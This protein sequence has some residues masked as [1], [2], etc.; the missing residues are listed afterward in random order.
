MMNQANPLDQLRPNHL[1]DPVSWFPPASGWWLGSL[2][3]VF[4][5][6]LAAWLVVRAIRRTRYR[7]Q[8]RKA[9]SQLWLEYQQH[10]NDRQFAHE[11]GSLLKRTALTAYPEEQVA[12]LHGQE[13]LKFLADKSNNPDFLKAAGTALGESRYSKEQLVDVQALHTMTLS[14]IR[15]HHA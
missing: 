3:I 10:G 6:V 14:W 8:A 5:V 13:W 15:K 7:R 9:A 12:C 11:C 4:L 1:P 2:L